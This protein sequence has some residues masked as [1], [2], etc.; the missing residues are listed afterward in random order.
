[1]LSLGVAGETITLTQVTLGGPG[2]ELAMQMAIR[3]DGQEHRIESGSPEVLQARWIDSRVL[4]VIV[5][6]GRQTFA[7]GQYELSEDGATLTISTND[8]VVV[9]ERA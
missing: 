4:E 3:A 9:F 1:M 8:H 7:R 2:H 5:K 6:R